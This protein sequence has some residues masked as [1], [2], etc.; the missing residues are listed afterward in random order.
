MYILCAYTT[1][2]EYPVY[3]KSHIQDILKEQNQGKIFLNVLLV[4]IA[5]YHYPLMVQDVIYI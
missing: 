2:L 4:M 5:S 3:N 1:V